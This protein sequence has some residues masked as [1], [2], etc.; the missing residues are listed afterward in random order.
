VKKARY[1][2][3]RCAKYLPKFFL[4]I[5]LF[6]AL[7]SANANGQPVNAGLETASLHF[8][9]QPTELEVFNARVFD[10]PLIPLGGKPKP[11]DTQALAD[12]LTQYANRSSPD[13]FSSLT[14]FLAHFPNSVWSPSL[15]LHLGI[16]YYRSG[17]FS[18]A[19]DA[20]QRAWKECE[21]LTDPKERT[22]ADRSL[23]ELARLYSKL[24]RMAELRQLLDEAKNRQLEGPATKLVAD[25]KDALWL[26]QNMPGIS[27]RCG[28][29]G[30]PV[31]K[32]A[33]SQWEADQV[34][35][36]NSRCSRFPRRLSLSKYLREMCCHELGNGHPRVAKSRHSGRLAS[37]PLLVR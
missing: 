33:A 23:G 7:L 11:E 37:E 14:S 21:P 27:F 17:Y 24:G 9:Q 36:G 26:M 18:R 22:Q 5:C 12:D 35:P 30:L 19:L 31:L 13:D 34:E 2:F 25:A 4:F 15:L 28:P 1:K 20:W 32:R 29:F 6:Y 3:I 10:E 8:S 16:E